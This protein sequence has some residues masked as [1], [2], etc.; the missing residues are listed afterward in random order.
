MVTS[1]K[2]IG[3]AKAGGETPPR[4]YPGLHRFASHGIIFAQGTECQRRLCCGTCCGTDQAVKEPHQCAPEHILSVPSGGDEEEVDSLQEDPSA[5]KAKES[6][7]TT[8]PRNDGIRVNTVTGVKGGIDSEGDEDT[9]TQGARKKTVVDKSHEKDGVE[10]D[11]ENGVNQEVHHG[12]IRGRRS[13]VL[14]GAAGRSLPSQVHI[15]LN[16]YD[17]E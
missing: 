4:T 5:V 7:A 15:P 1:G 6:D 9:G 13:Q 3:E 14:A 10:V 16:V 11:P 8:K 17:E 2:K 12:T